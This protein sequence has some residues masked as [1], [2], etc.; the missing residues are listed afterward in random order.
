MV[1]IKTEI[2]TAAVGRR[3]RN[4]LCERGLRIAASGGRGSLPALAT[5]VSRDRPATSA[6]SIP[7][8]EAEMQALDEALAPG[9][10][11][12]PRYPERMMATIDR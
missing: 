9:K 1:P 12:G 6:E 8:S 7:L 4:A 10:T 2:G 3:A 11:S 5:T